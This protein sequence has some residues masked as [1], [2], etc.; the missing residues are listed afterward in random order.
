MLPTAEI[1]KQWKADL[2]LDP[3]LDWIR[4][5]A[6]LFTSLDTDLEKVQINRITTP[7][8]CFNCQCHSVLT[9]NIVFLTAFQFL[10]PL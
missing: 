6:H 9:V 8:L 1:L 3:I 7:S 4:C 2:D 5:N 10:K